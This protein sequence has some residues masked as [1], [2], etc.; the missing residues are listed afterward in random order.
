MAEVVR[1]KKVVL[2][3]YIT[4]FLKESDMEVVARETISISLKTPDEGSP[5][6]VLV[7]N[8]SLSCDPYMRRRM[9]HHEEPSYVPDFVP[10]SVITGFGVAKVVDSRNPNFVKGDL[11]WGMT[12]WEEY[13]LIQEAGHLFKIKYID[14]PLSYYTGLLGMPGFTAY[15]GFYEVCSPKKGEYV[16]IS[17]ASGAVGQLVGQFAKL[18]GCHVVGSAGSDEKVEILKNKLGFDE[19]FN[20]KKEPDLN[21]ALKRD[22]PEG[23]DIYFDNVGGAM[24]DA[25]LPNM[26]LQGRIAACGMISQYNL[27]QQ[28]DVHNLLYIVTKR[29]RMEGFFVF[30]YLHKFR[31]FEDKVAQ[32]VREV[33]IVYVE[34]IVEGLENAPAA[35]IGL[36]T[37]RNVGKQLVVCE[38]AD[39]ERE[40]ERGREMEGGVGNKKVVLRHYVTGFPKEDD[41][42]VVAAE[43]I[44]LKVP[45]GSSE[46]VLVKN[47]YISCD[48]YMRGRMSKYEND[49]SY[50]PDLLPGSV[51]T[52]LGVARVVDS[53]NPKFVKG[54]LVWGMTGWEEYS[55]IENPEGLH[56]ITYADV[57][58]SYYTG[59]LGMPGLTAYYGFYDVCSPKKGEYVFIS[60]A[61]GAVGQL[62]G[63]FAKL[64]GCYVVGSAG[65]D[66]KVELLKN[67]F[68]F[69]EAFNYKKENDWN[70]ALKRYF[71]E[72]IDIYFENVGGAMLDA[73][74]VNMRLHGRIAVCGLIS[75]YNLEKPDGVHNLF[76]LVSKRIRMEGFLVTD[77]FHKCGEFEEK[78]IQYIREGKIVYLEDVVEGLESAPAALLRLFTGSNVGKQLVV[79]SRERKDA[80]DAITN[81]KDH[82]SLNETSHC[83]RYFPE[84]IDIYFENVGGAM[85]EA[86]LVNMR[87]H[88]RIAVCGLISQYNLE[89]PEG[90]QLSVLSRIQSHPDG[91]IPRT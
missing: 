17:A 51:I 5:A 62:V 23:I 66:K 14:L 63:Q 88:G 47:L 3:H 69:D 75:Q 45:E 7:K 59:V 37:G 70:A 56:K 2:R 29:I 42:E 80:P 61:S 64:M 16:F 50:I 82:T 1:N 21:A 77:Y 84:E 89:K 15:V 73:V 52:G 91:G 27:E 83:T 76:C 39:R 48:P 6:A 54:D 79:V 13:S 10:G 46:A 57:P 49:S 85:L 68:G 36:F 18:M 71:P 24:L 67:K 4:G 11:V 65:S 44:P 55:L 43:T 19:A 78:V 35:L 26:R 34:D 31:E 86:V 20:Y 90:V 32:F 87:L 8:L 9:S 25:V 28:E 22:L 40:R 30:S 60:A 58:L 81:P 12:G 33:K 53:T 72:G 41:M 38:V 74:L